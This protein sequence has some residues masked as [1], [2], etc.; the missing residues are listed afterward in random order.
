MRRGILKRGLSAIVSLAVAL[1]VLQGVS[2]PVTAEPDPTTIV[3][4]DYEYEF[5][6]NGA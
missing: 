1:A 2:V 5:I 4:G 6:D 3:C